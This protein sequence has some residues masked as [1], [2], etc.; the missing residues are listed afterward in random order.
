[1]FD[2]GRFDESIAT[3]M[4]CLNQPGLTHAFK[5]KAY[6]LLAHNYMAKS[7]KERI[8][9]AIQEILKLDPSYKAPED[10]P[11]F[12]E[13]VQKVKEQMTAQAPVEEKGKKPEEKALP[14]AEKKP[15]PV[16]VPP[17]AVTEEEGG[18][19]TWHWIAGGA[20]VGGVVLYLVL[21]GGGDGGG[22]GTTQPK[23]PLPPPR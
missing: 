22:G 2:N 4:K 8:T 17:E 15:E 10:E 13:Q 3:I 7:N 19:Q 6:E 11:A 21:K 1:M 12:A 9:L 23:V 18:L 5:V 14:Q 16:P 20:A